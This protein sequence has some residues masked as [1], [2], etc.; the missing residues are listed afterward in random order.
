[1]HGLG[2]T[3]E[4]MRLSSITDNLCE[5]NSL[6]PSGEVRIVPDVST[7]CR[8]PWVRNQEMVLVDMLTEPGKAWQYC[9][10]DVLRRFST[11]LEDEFGLVMNV[12]IEVEFYLLKSVIKDGKETWAAIDRSSY[13]ST[14]AIDVASSVLEEVF[15]SLQSLNIIVEQL[16]SEAGKGQFE[17]VLGYT[18]CRRAANNLIITHEIIKG[19]ARKHGLL[20]SFMPRYYYDNVYPWY[21]EYSKDDVGSGSHLHISLSKNG[22]NV[23]MASIEPNRYGMTKIGESFMAGV[24]DHLRSICVFTMPIENSY[25]RLMPKSWNSSYLCWGLECKELTIRACCPPGA[26]DG[27]V[28]NFEIKTFDGSANPHLGLACIIIAGI[29]G[30]RRNLPIPDPVEPEADVFDHND[31][32]DDIRVPASLRCS[33]IHIFSDEWFK[34][35]LG[36]NFLITRRGICSEEIGHY[37]MG[38]D[39]K[40]V[41]CVFNY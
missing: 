11:I 3:V 39:E 4:C 1:M 41:H 27:V 20:A 22:E 9:P 7:K 17:I 38:R 18:D 25:E 15:V 35:M 33:I 23:F 14:A 29:D 37:M 10:K 32:N 16:H 28:T 31:D 2:L 19:I 24:L 34:E 30:L 36:E 40:Y 8:L 21:D 12:G 13:C 6:S 5:E 26:P